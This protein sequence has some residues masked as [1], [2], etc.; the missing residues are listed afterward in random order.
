MGERDALVSRAVEGAGAKR[1]GLGAGDRADAD[2]AGRGADSAGG[3]ARGQR[4]RLRPRAER[5]LLDQLAP[6]E[7]APRLVD[8]ALH[9]LPG[10]GAKFLDRARRQIAVAAADPGYLDPKTGYFV[11]TEVS[12]LANGSCCESGCR[13]WATA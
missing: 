6:P 1:R 2:V 12:L 11:F 8:L 3:P 4:Q 5:P 13:N 7:H 10:D 9:A